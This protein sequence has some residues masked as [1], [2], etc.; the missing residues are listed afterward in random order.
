MPVLG[1]IAVNP[2]FTSPRTVNPLTPEVCVI[3][4]GTTVRGNLAP[5]VQPI[6]TPG[7]LMARYVAMVALNVVALQLMPLSTMLETPKLTV[8]VTPEEQPPAPTV[9]FAQ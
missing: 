9:P 3:E 4:D 8:A 7:V 5:S 1:A 2:P 6:K